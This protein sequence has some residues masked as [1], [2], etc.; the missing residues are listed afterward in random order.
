MLLHSSEGYI[1]GEVE[2]RYCST[3][4]QY[5]FFYRVVCGLSSSEHLVKAGG[6]IGMYMP[7]QLVYTASLQSG[8][9]PECWKTAVITPIFKKGDPSVPANYRPVSITAAT[10][11]KFEQ[12]FVP[13]LLWRLRRERQFSDQQYGALKGRPTELQL[14]HCLNTV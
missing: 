2:V 13:Y 11:W 9:L 1:E 10:A 6:A 4:S 3:V 14:L 8:V 7:F 5:R 12:L